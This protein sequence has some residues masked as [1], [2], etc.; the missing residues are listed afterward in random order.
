VN[1]AGTVIAGDH[2]CEAISVFVGNV[3]VVQ[4]LRAGH[5]GRRDLHAGVD[6][7]GQLVARHD[8]H[9]LARELLARVDPAEVVRI[10]LGVVGTRHD[11]VDE[12]EVGVVLGPRRRSRQGQV[13][14]R[15][16]ELVDVVLR[17]RDVLRGGLDVVHQVGDLDLDDV[18]A[19]PADGL[20]R[21]GGP[22]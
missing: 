17:A 2:V 5:R 22:R 1:P 21:G 9:R 14:A 4:S 8:V 18:A 12:I 10:V 16:E 19:G 11:G 20:D 3:S 13:G 15:G 6:E 7:R